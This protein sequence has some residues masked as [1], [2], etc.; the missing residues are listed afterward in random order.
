MA[1]VAVTG[2]VLCLMACGRGDRAE[3]ASTL[4]ATST[5]ATNSSASESTVSR[6]PIPP[7][8]LRDDLVEHGLLVLD[9]PRKAVIAQLGQ[10]DSIH[11]QTEQSRYN[12]AQ[13]DSTIDV[14]YPGLQIG[15]AHV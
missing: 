7:D 14:F 11:S 1:R 5:L 6:R 3:R 15:R 10:P 12:P 9:G 2:I 4:E 13:T 8:S